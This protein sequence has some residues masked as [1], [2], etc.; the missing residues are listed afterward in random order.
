MSDLFEKQPIIEKTK[1]EKL[2]EKFCDIFDKIKKVEAIKLFKLICKEYQSEKRI[3]HNLEHIEKL[4]NFIENYEKE[5]QDEK[6]LKLAVWFHDVI[7]NTQAKDNEE[8]SADY[9]KNY[10]EKLDFSK[11]TVEHVVALIMSTKKHETIENDID[12]GILLDGDLAILG[13]NEK[14]YDKY[15]TKIREEYAWVLD[16]EYKE[17]RIKVLKK[18]LERPKIYFTEKAEKELEQQARINIEREI[19]QLS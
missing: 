8:Q 1:I 10:L 18:F 12:S 11:E 4:L 5:I 19:K 9:A 7:Y 3:Y 13:S 6:G 16:K 17:G 15:A 14:E 2:Q